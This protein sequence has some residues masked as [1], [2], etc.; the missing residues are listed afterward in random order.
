MGAAGLLRTSGRIFTVAAG[1]TILATGGGG[2]LYYPHTD[3]TR[4]TT[5]DGYA[6][7]FEAGADLVDMEQVQF[8][9]FALTHPK[10]MVGIVCGEP[11]TVGPKGKILNNEGREILKGAA[12]KTRAEVSK[13]IILEVENGNGTKYGG[14]NLDLYANKQDPG[15]Q[16]VKKAYETTLKALS[17]SVKFAYGDKAEN[18][19]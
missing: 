15:G 7:A 13:A 16:R 6:L 11:F 10:S 19:E 1:Q 9:P 3:V 4:T 14:V 18:W 12:A 17:D 8:I 2:W 5:G